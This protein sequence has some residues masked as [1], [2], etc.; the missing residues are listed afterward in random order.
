MASVKGKVY[1]RNS[2]LLI[3][4]DKA[5]G[6]VT[7]LNAAVAA[8]VN[9]IDLVANPGTAFAIGKTIRVGDGNEMELNRITGITGAGPFTATLAYNTTHAHA[10][11][12]AVVEMVS[13]DFGDIEAA[14]FSVT[15]DGESQ[16]VLVST[17]RLPYTILDGYKDL[18]GS[19]ALPNV[20]IDNFP[21]AFGMLGSV[22]SGA[23]TVADPKGFATD[24]NQFAADP[25]VGITV[26]GVLMDGTVTYT[27]LWGVDADYTGMSLALVRGQLAS[28]PVKVLAAAGGVT[29][30]G[31]PGYTVDASL[32]PTKNKVL[33][34]ITEV[35]IFSASGTLSTTVATAAAAAGQKTVECAAVTG[36]TPGDLVKIGTGDQA[37]W[38]EIDS[39]SAPNLVLRTPLFRTQPVGTPVVEAGRV[40]FAGVSQEGVK[41]DVGGSVDKIRTA[42]SATSIGSRPGSAVMTLSFATIDITLSQLAYAL[43]IS[44]ASIVANRLPMTGALV[45]R[46]P[47]DGAYLKGLCADGS[48]FEIRAWACAQSITQFVLQLTNQGTIPQAPFTLRPT[49]GLQVL[50]YQ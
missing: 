21:L 35:G 39:V 34:A 26:I 44:Q 4:R 48:T 19:F 16:D 7:T 12:D 23:G 17:K 13:Y 3:H 40:S 47:V 6:G 14:G 27:E 46:S 1:Q 5:S 9:S 42:I 2:Q 30:T 31:A 25:N 11:G 8:G 43:G 15:V 41:L 33:T 18:G 45:G 50:N 20:S 10:A 32:R 29:G 28:I 22:V 36:A 24:G 37:E 49:S 38:H